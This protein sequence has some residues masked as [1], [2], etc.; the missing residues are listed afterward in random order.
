MEDTIFKKAVKTEKENFY[1]NMIADLRQKHPCQWYSSLKRICGLDQ[2]SDIAKVV[3]INNL[4]DKEQSEKISEYFSSIPNNYKPI[5]N[6]DPPFT[7]KNVPQFHASEVWM[8][9]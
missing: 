9:N 6:F 4:S 7:Q 8:P 5:K 2:K 1:K 3:E